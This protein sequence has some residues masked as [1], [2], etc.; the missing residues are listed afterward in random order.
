MATVIA[1]LIVGP[2][3]YRNINKFDSVI[4]PDSRQILT[5]E[6]TWRS[7]LFN[8]GRNLASNAG[9]SAVGPWVAWL[10]QALNVQDTDQRYSYTAE[11]FGVKLTSSL[12]LPSTA[13][14]PNESD[15]PSPVHVGVLLLSIF[16]FSLLALVSAKWSGKFC[17]LARYGLAASITVVAFCTLI[18]WH[19]WITREQ[20]GEFAL[21][22]PPA[23]VLISNLTVIPSTLMLIL[24]F[25]AVPAM[26][27]NAY[28]PI[29]G[30]PWSI[31]SASPNDVLFANWPGLKAGYVRLAD[32]IAELRPAQ[33]G[34]FIEDD[35]WEF[36]L[37]Y[38][39]RQRLQKS[40]MPKIIHE[41]NEQAIDP[42]SDVVVY[43]YNY[44]AR[45]HNADPDGMIE[46][47]GF[48]PLRLYQRIR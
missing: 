2:Q 22:I 30:P 39:L 14:N 19:P 9:T 42:R 37:W 44:Y 32:K 28:R 15:A 12:H 34:L 6:P 1:L 24:G 47:P 48:D 43:I 13:L 3:L 27:H 45:A 29:I 25:Q 18:K 10:G 26:F 31:I 38:L 36:P 11:H 8:A 23:A 16:G 7:T 17:S 5:V 4:G 33:V 35:S 40:D 20:L 21:V 46:V 41:L